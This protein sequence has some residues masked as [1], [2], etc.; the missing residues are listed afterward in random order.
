MN[1]TLDEEVTEAEKAVVA[2]E[3]TVADDVNVAEEAK[4][5]ENAERAEEATKD[6][7]AEE[8]T[9]NAYSNEASKIAEQAAEEFI[10]EL[11]DF[12]SNWNKLRLKLC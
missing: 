7:L 9:G 12:R 2:E 8:V 10:C 3:V 4:V 5:C 6:K 11:F 1:D